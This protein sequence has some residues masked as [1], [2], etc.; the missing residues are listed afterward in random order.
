[1][2]KINIVAVKGSV[3]NITNQIANIELYTNMFREELSSFS[4]GWNSS[5]A[6]S[7]KSSIEEIIVS[8]QAAKE[9]LRKIN[10]KINTTAQNIETI[11]SSRI[12][13]S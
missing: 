9:S 4:Q 10:E 1:M 8:L 2:E 11:D 12:T 3:T 6:I 5:N 7:V 13:N